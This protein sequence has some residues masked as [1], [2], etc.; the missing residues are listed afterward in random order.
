VEETAEMEEPSVFVEV[1]ANDPAMP[2]IVVVVAIFAKFVVVAI[3][4]KFVV[5]VIF[6]IQASITAVL[7]VEGAA[8]WPLGEVRAS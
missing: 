3:F 6:V 7:I 8:L 1:A 2:E 5:L 4:A